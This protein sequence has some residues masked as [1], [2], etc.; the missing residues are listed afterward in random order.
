MNLKYLLLFFFCL[1]WG[2]FSETLFERFNVYAPVQT[3]DFSKNEQ[4]K[5]QVLKYAEEEN[6]LFR[7]E[8]LQ[9]I[10][11]EEADILLE[12]FF[13]SKNGIDR[14]RYRI[15]EVNLEQEDNILWQMDYRTTSN[16]KFFGYLHYDE[17]TKLVRLAS[18][19]KDDYS[20]QPVIYEWEK[21]TLIRKNI[22]SI[23]I[24]PNISYDYLTYFEDQGWGYFIFSQNSGTVKNFT[25]L[26][27]NISDPKSRLWLAGGIRG[28]L[29]SFIPYELL[30]FYSSANKVSAEV[31]SCVNS[32]TI[33]GR[34]YT[35]IESN[36]PAF[37]GDAMSN[38]RQY[39]ELSES[40]RYY[41]VVMA[42]AENEIVKSSKN[43]LSNSQEAALKKESV[44]ARIH[45]WGEMADIAKQYF[46]NSAC[47]AEFKVLFSQND[48]FSHRFL[49][50]EHVVSENDAK[51]FYDNYKWAFRR[52]FNSQSEYYSFN[53]VEDFIYAEIRRLKSYG[54][55]EF[56]N[57]PPKVEIIWKK[58]EAPSA[59]RGWFD[60]L[61]PEEMERRKRE[62]LASQPLK[63]LFSAAELEELFAEPDYARLTDPLQLAR[64]YDWA[65]KYPE[66]LAAFEKA[67]GIEAKFE[68][69]CFLKHGRPGIPADKKRANELFA[70][71]ATSG[72]LKSGIPTAMEYCLAGRASSEY[73][74]ENWDETVRWR[75]RAAGFFQKSIAQ[76]Y[77]PA[78]YYSQYYLRHSS[79]KNPQELMKALPS[80]NPE[81]NA[82]IGALAGMN[83]SS[84]E[85]RNRDKNLAAIKAG[86]QAYNNVA[87]CALGMLYLHSETDPNAFLRHNRQKAKFWLQRAAD[88]GDVDAIQILQN[89]SRLRNL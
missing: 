26:K 11:T 25:V 15:R 33:N 13:Y 31:S 81:V 89:D 5:R 45:A 28:V 53:E 61:P 48:F 69:G 23:S 66:A 62:F 21:T 49:Q 19:R 8:I 56:V 1:P 71:I 18:V 27:L 20:Y 36:Y 76:G 78:C 84:K 14:Y 51:R 17:T 46:S 7:S 22:Y 35:H 3:V 60:P 59:K 24:F 37:F 40:Y 47:Q 57:T 32:I 34:A 54:L 83:Q 41:S 63:E 38:Y 2:C 75:K 6:K 9:K 52:N 4:L 86:I 82:F 73:I 43:I 39:Y 58:E 88:R 30:L 64:A 10:K 74:P 55:E 87:Q 72:D 85:P 16:Q 70:E 65:G 29:Y 50:G 12:K 80:D 42:I 79:D 67:D 44:L 68:L 77:R